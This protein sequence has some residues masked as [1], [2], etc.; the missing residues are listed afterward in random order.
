MVVPYYPYTRGTFKL[1]CKKKMLTE[2]CYETT[3]DKCLACESPDHELP[4]YAYKYDKYK[5]FAKK[6]LEILS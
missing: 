3:L 2:K 6:I 5:A 1:V 4:T